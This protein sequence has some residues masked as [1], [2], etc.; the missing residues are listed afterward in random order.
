MMQGVEKN[1]TV[2]Y[3]CKGINNVADGQFIRVAFRRINK[4]CILL[5]SA[6]YSGLNAKLF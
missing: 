5:L 6:V 3:P 1:L 4:Q 2:N